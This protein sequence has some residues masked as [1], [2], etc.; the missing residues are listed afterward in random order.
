MINTL[1]KQIGEYKKDTII[2]P[3]FT[4][5][6]VIA[7]L[8]VP[9]VIASLIDKGIEAGN[10][11]NVYLYGALMIVLAFFGLVFGILAGRFAASASSGFACNLRQS[12]FENIQTFSFSNIDKFS[13]AGLV[14][15]M[16]TD[17]TNMQMAFQMC[18]RI[19]LRAPL[20]LIC[21]MVMCLLINA[22]LSMI[23]LAAI[24]VLAVALVFIMS[25]AMK[26]FSKVFHRY[27]DLNA[28]VQ[29]NISAIRVVKA[30][31]R[32]DYENEKFSKAA[33]R[34]YELFVNA[35]KLQALNLPVMMSI[36]YG[37]IIAISWFGAHFIVA[38]S[39]TTGNLTSLFTYVMTAFSSL[40]MLSMIFVMMT[41]SAAS[42][43]RIAEVLEEKADI[44]NPKKPLHA[45]KDGSIDFDH[46]SF[47]YRRG[48]GKATLDGIDLHIKSGETVGV[49]G[50]T[51]CGKSSL[52]SLI[53]RLYDVT[54][55]S[56]KV[57]GEDVRKYDLNILRNQVAVVLQKTCCFLE[58]Y[59]RICAGAKRWD[60]RENIGMPAICHVQ[61][62]LSTICQMAMKVGLNGAE[63]TSPVGRNSGFVLPE[64]CSKT[65]RF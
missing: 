63:R 36:V 10:L 23:F 21:S 22:K 57:G 48:S 51:G 65:P 52:V 1:L 44:A 59:W 60:M 47:S 40:M 6:E 41:M 32:E 7:E 14:T 46:V 31:V 5:L 15:R 35:E 49:I 54:S 34:L 33:T 12:M 19:A 20:M 4:V 56:V 39:M 24:V 64:H 28:S 50:S 43:K 18:L 11:R 55:G 9:F 8:L 38:G 29:E 61:M 30:F 45:V 17:V 62:S 42:G 3:V 25:K 27:D 16:T 13:T 2:T 58:Q 37:C 53:S 26:I